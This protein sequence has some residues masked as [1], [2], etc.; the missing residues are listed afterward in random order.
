[1]TSNNS[2]DVLVVPRGVV[3]ILRGFVPWWAIDPITM[4][5]LSESCDWS[6]RLSA[7]RSPDLVQLIP[8]AVVRDVNGNYSVS[9]RI[10][11]TREDL[12]WKLTLLYGGH[13]E[14]VEDGLEFTE[15]LQANLLRELNEEL[16][17][18]DVDGME[19][20]GTVNDLTN[21]ASSRHIAVVF[22]VS[23]SDEIS[24]R[25]REEFSLGSQYCGEFLD[26]ASL[27]PLEHRLDPWSKLLFHN[28]ITPGSSRESGMQIG[29]MI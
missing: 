28:W 18:S 9:R 7:E 22:D 14:R 12:H 3:S 24:V 21:L 1:M 4:A 5:A 10:G 27:V 23:T 20:I 6:P 17:V 26:S 15:L 25:A 16:G 11:A 2:Q 19:I 13:I 8:C 29:L